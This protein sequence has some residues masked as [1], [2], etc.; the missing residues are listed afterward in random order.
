[1]SNTIRLGTVWSVV[2]VGTETKSS[3]RSSLFGSTQ[4]L[5]NV[6]YR[7]L[8]QQSGANNA[9][10]ITLYKRYSGTFH[11]NISTCAHRE[12]NV[13]LRQSRCII[14]SVTSHSHKVSFALKTFYDAGLILRKNLSSY[15]IG[16]DY[17][18][19]T[20]DGRSHG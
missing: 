16:T 15:I 17:Q 13:R 6:L 18:E 14:D 5:F 1:M 3:A 10:Q 8:A 19:L 20:T 11:R 4:I 12:P 9:V 2:I 7:L